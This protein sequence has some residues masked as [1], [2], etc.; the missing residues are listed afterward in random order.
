MHMPTGDHERTLCGRTWDTYLLSV[1]EAYPICPD[2]WEHL[3]R[4]DTEII[5]I[6]DPIRRPVEK[7]EI[8]KA[9]AQRLDQS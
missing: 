7:A 2:C 3:G 8:I 1:G 5:E 4:D 9:I 6:P